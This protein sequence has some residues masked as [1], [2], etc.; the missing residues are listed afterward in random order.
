MRPPLIT[1][2]GPRDGLQNEPVVLSPATRAELCRRLAAAGLTRIEAVSFVSPKHVPA[3]AGPEEVL[4]LLLLLEELLAD[5]ACLSSV[6]VVGGSRP[7]GR[8]N[9]DVVVD[10]HV[11][12]VA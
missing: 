9:G 8:P 10:R 5:H 7:L 1:D 6:A 11:V 12:P 3:M 2:V 4:D